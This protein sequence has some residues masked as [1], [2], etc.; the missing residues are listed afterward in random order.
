MYKIFGRNENQITN[1]LYRNLGIRIYDH[2]LKP[3]CNYPL[4][5]K[6]ISNVYQT[7][8]ISLNYKNK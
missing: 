4:S 8:I 7:S 1:S 5:I 3:N 2:V 6:I